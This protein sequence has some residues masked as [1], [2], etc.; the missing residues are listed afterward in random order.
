LQTRQD[1]GAADRLKTANALLDARDAAGEH[2]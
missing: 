2:G 1:A